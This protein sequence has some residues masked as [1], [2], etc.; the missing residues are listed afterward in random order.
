MLHIKEKATHYWAVNSFP[1]ITFTSM[2]ICYRANQR[3]KNIA[4]S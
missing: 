1:F 3:L 4:Y 2:L